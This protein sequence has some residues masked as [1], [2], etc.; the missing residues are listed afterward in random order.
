[1]NFLYAVTA[2]L[3]I[4]FLGSHKVPDES[5]DLEVESDREFLDIATSLHKGGLENLT[6]IK[7][8]L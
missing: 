2:I 1:M 8:N 5:F 4:I 3:I 7:V 6:T